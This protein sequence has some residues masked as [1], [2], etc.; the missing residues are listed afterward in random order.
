MKMVYKRKDARFGERM[1]V[2]L[3]RRLH[4]LLSFFEVASNCLIDE[5]A[6]CSV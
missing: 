5:V 6:T 1:P 3:F 4:N 2:D